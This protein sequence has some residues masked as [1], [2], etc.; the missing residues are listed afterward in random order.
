MVKRGKWIGVFLP[1]VMLLGA[2]GQAASQS[3]EEAQGLAKNADGYVEISADQLAGMM[4]DKSLVLVNVHVPY[5][6]EIPNTDLSVPFD[7]IQDHLDELPDKEAPIVLY[8]RSGGMSTTAAEVLVGQ[9]YSNVMELEGGFSAWKA[10]G[11]E[12]LDS[13]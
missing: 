4:D 6:G 7:Q 1:L 3:V 10:Q 8:C 5:E 9:G 11:Y 2:C 12:L 13:Q